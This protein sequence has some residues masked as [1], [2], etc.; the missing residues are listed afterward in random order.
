MVMNDTSEQVLPDEAATL[1]LASA[2]S[3][4]CTPGL[5]IYLRGDLGAGKTT[6]TRGLLAGLGFHGRVKSPTYTLVES[7]PLPG[8]TV[9]HFD[10]YRFADPDEWDDA[11]FRDYFGPDALCLVE[12]PDKGGGLLPPPDLEL[13]LSVEGD[14][15]RYRLTA[16]TETGSSCLT[17]HSTQAAADY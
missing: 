4:A 8:I 17:R 16:F 6:F 10:L 11:G 5:V 1:A 13:A 3:R 9:H 12:W 14:G 2:F 15:R 7:Y